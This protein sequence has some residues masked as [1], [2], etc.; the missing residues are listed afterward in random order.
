MRALIVLAA[1]LSCGPALAAED[2]LPLRPGPGSELAAAACNACHTTNYIIM[3]STF[4]PAATWKA[5][6]T[7]MRTAFGAPIEDSIA[8][9]I[10]AY[11]IANYAAN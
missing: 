7:K 5:E 11:L 3:N 1:A 10:T 6:V 4:L 8:E 9:Q 2:P